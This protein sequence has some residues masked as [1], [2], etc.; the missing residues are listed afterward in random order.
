MDE[1]FTFWSPSG[2][3]LVGVLFTASFF[4][5]IYVMFVRHDIVSHQ[6]VN[7]F[8]LLRTLCALAAGLGQVQSDVRALT[9]AVISHGRSIAETIGTLRDLTTD[10]LALARTVRESCRDVTGLT[11]DPQAPATPVL[12]EILSELRK[13]PPVQPTIQSRLPPFSLQFFSKV[14]AE[15]LARKRMQANPNPFHDLD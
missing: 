15:D 7:I 4:L 11:T 12:L 1:S 6:L 14:Q 5:S 8:E 13:K 3:T 9:M 10:L 2:W